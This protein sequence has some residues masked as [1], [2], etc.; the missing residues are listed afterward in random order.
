MIN[1]FSRAYKDKEIKQILNSI[2]VLVDSREKVNSHIKMWL[3]SNKI[4]YID[5]TLSF[6]DYSFMIPKNE[7]L[8]ILEDLYFTYEIAIERKAHAE[9]MKTAQVVVEEIKQRVIE[10]ITIIKS[11]EDIFENYLDKLENIV[12][13]NINFPTYS[14][15]DKK[16]VAE[17]FSIAKTLKNVCDAPIIDEN[18]KITRKSRRILEDTKE[19]F[20]KLEEI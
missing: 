1:K 2:T 9:E 13:K 5:Y 10:F 4:K 17:T 20:I 3:K 14:D 15:I 16:T 8:D 7:S 6:G 11:L 12:D 19:F 18:G